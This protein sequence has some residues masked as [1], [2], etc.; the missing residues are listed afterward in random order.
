MEGVGA[1]LII[2]F[3]LAIAAAF[4]KVIYKSRASERKGEEGEAMVRASLSR[5][6]EPDER[7]I[8]NYIVVDSNGKSHQIDHI[9]IMRNGIFC[10][11]T[12]NFKGWIF[13][14]ENSEKWTQTLYNGEKHQ[15]LNPFKQNASHCYHLSKIIGNQFKIVSLVV[16]A[17]NNAER[18][19]SKYALNIRDLR[20]FLKNYYD[21]TYLS[22]SDVIEIHNRLLL[23]RSNMTNKEH[24]ENIKKTQVELKNNICPRCGGKLVLRN[25]RGCF[26]GCSNYPKCKFTKKL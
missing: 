23:A 4:I 25:G 17:D 12:K 11:E 6:L 22:E 3:V 21:G 9:A 2:F 7:V 20:S 24:V 26:L 5:I 1:L 10:I 14:D 13:G 8:N 18:I 15:F 16:M 19:E